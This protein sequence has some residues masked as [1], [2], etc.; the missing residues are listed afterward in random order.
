[1][2]VPLQVHG[3]LP[4]V[5]NL[6]FGDAVLGEGLLHQ[7]V[8]A[9]LLI[10]QNA[11]YHGFRPDQ[12]ALCGGD[13]LGLQLRLDHTDA[14][15]GQE[16][17]INLANDLRLFRNDPGLAVLALLVAV[18]VLILNGHLALLHGLALSPDDVAGHGLAFRLSESAHHGDQDLAVGLQGVDILLLEDDR[19]P[20]GAEGPDIVE[21]VHGVPGEAGNGFDQDQVDLTLPAL[22][23]HPQEGGALGG[24]GARD[25][26]VRENPGHGP[27]RIRHDLIRV[28]VLLGLVAG[29]LLLVVGGYPAVGGDAELALDGLGPG[30]L[31]LGRDHDHLG[32][33]PC[34]MH[35]SILKR[36]VL[37]GRPGSRIVF[38]Q[39]PFAGLLPRVM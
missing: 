29:E 32:G 35:H 12:T 37:S 17:V 24:G 30:Q 5:P 11:P 38:F 10:F 13:A 26:F 34:H 14:V 16:A 7:R 36:I 25:A 28:V 23:D 1:M 27:L 31:R 8:A 15:P 22:A 18:E 3:E 2:V 21:A 6:L 9:I 33:S 20:H 39:V 19:D 4:D